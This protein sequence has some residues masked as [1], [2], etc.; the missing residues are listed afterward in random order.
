MA[1]DPTA[2]T[3]TRI[4]VGGLGQSVNSDDLRKIFSA[5]GTV[6]GVDIVRT[7]G[8]SFAYVD[9]LPSTSNSISKLFS[10]YNGCA[11]KGGKLKLEKAKEHFLIR[12]KREWAEAEAEDEANEGSHQAKPSSSDS[13]NSKNKV[14]VSQ[15]NQLRIF[16]P[17]LSKI[18]S[19]PFSG[20]GKHRYSFQRVEALAFP[21]H[22]CDCAEHSG[23]FNAVKQ[24]EVRRH[25]EIND[26]M[27]EEELSLMSSVMNKLFERENISNTSRPTI[28]KE[29]NDFI[30]PVKDLPSNEEE[31]DD[32]DDDLIINVVSN[33][34]KRTAMSRIGES[35]KVSTEKTRLSE[36]KVSKDGAI[37]SASKLQKKNALHAEK[38][39]KPNRDDK[40]EI[41]SL[42]SQLRMNSQCDEIEAGFEEDDETDDD[43]VINVA[44]TESKGKALSGS[45]KRAKVS[46]KQNFK[47]SET[48][49]TENEREE[50][51]DRLLPKKK[52]KL[53][54]TKERDGNEA[55]STVP[56]EKG[57]LIAQMTE[58][59][60]SLKPSS[61]SCLWSQ[62][63]SWKALVGGRGDSAFSLSNILQNADTT[64]EQHIFDDPKVD[65]TLDSKNDK[66]STPE[67]LE[68]MSDKMEIANAIAE[69]QPNKPSMTSSN[70]G[71]GS[72]WLHKSSWTQLVSD[73]SNSFSISQILPGTTTSQELAKPTGEDVVQSA[74]GNYT[75]EMDRF[76]TEGVGQ[77]DSV[78]SIPKTSPQTLEGSNNTSLPAVENISNFEPVKG[79][80]VDTSTGGT[81]SFMRS[82]TSLKEWAKT[83]AALK[84]SRK[85]KTK[86]DSM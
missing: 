74:D 14:Q 8:R 10:T 81:C 39:R 32:D 18:K 15:N 66:L 53:I 77:G 25:E 85:K 11:W 80:A 13:N 31:N 27:N 57:P 38:K 43:L 23:R 82:S 55:V 47:P 72:S 76:T 50:K 3:R 69:A 17:R 73:K 48:Q 30:E 33:A 58:Q 5:V 26:G 35:K 29:R 54:S 46:P 68:G 45:T 65:N 44:S 62:K 19:L 64:E 22:F 28:V 7:K 37:P 63:S 40:H 84:G 24:K 34:N 36:N 71:R 61:T 42:S 59:D 1:A 6:E 79:F 4:H 9:I 56:A 41:T 67:N 83:K 16:F 86:G 70:T 52:M 20:T 75:N 51:K 60:C 21:L 49:S 78:E 12:L 2:T